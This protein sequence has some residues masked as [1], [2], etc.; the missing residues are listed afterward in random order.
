[1]RQTRHYDDL[2]KWAIE[3][4]KTEY[5]Y[6][7]N[8]GELTNMKTGNSKWR[9]DR[10]GYHDIGIHITED[11]IRT[12]T[13]FKVHQIAF[14]L[15]NGELPEVVDHINGIRTDNTWSNLRS[16][17]IRQ[18]VIHRQIYPGDN[19]T[20][21]RGVVFVNKKKSPNPYIVA[22]R[23][24]GKKKHLG[25]FDNV[26]DAAKAYDAAAIKYHGEFACLNFSTNKQ[27]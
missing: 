21:Y 22:I 2:P 13:H 24:N 11:G 14:I 5:N 12:D 17:T 15:M 19:K 7:P 1:M 23:V 9:I 18:N 6:N 26:I 10:Y 8:T 4:L 3:K 25:C 16:V 27:E 20:G